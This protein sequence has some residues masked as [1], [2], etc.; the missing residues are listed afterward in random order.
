[1][2]FASKESA[3]GPTDNKTHQSL[4]NIN[5]HLK[6][7]PAH[8]LTWKCKKA[9]SK[10]KV[11]FLQGSVHFHV[12]WEGTPYGKSLDDFNRSSCAASPSHCA[13]KKREENESPMNPGLWETRPLGTQHEFSC[14]QFLGPCNQPLN[15]FGLGP[16]GAAISTQS[17]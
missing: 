7:L 14:V 6:K 13:S 4:T 5:L 9:L 16:T 2:N 1:M 15:D 12:R 3:G 10:R 11:V 8:Q 17:A